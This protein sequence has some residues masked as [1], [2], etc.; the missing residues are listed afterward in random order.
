MLLR[1]TSSAFV[2]R[3]H[4]EGF[5]DVGDGFGEAVQRGGSGVQA[6]GES[7]PPGI[8]QRVDGVGGAGAE[9]LADLFDG[10]AV[11]AFLAR[12]IVSMGSR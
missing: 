11:A 10:G 2:E 3:L 8:Q 4:P 6:G 1:G 12:V 7:L 5:G 9:F